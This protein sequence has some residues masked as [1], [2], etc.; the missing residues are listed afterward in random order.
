METLK[1]YFR[2]IRN[3]AMYIGK[4]V[5]TVTASIKDEGLSGIPLLVVCRIENTDTL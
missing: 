5:G 3:D 1:K 2:L 4:V